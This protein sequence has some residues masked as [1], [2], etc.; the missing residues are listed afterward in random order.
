MKTGLKLALVTMCSVLVLGLLMPMPLSSADDHKE[1]KKHFQ[2]HD[3]KK[4]GWNLGDIVGRKRDKGN[5]T[6]GQMVAW[7]LAAANL[8]VV[9]SS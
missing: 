6:T 5:E 2:K 3:W 7:S 9:I 4:G 1:G 8:T